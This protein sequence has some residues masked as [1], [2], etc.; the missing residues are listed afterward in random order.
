MQAGFRCH[1][2]LEDLT[3]P[4]DY[5]VLRVHRL[6]TPLA[7]CFGDM[8]KAFDTIPRQ[9]L[10]RVLL[11]HYGINSDMVETIRHMYTNT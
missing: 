7:L 9:C 10:M 1:H 2:R 3:V 11:D 6:K 8:E 4:V 5:L